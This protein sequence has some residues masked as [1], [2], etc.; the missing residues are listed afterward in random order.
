MANVIAGVEG[1]YVI[2]DDQGQIFFVDGVQGGKAVADTLNPKPTP[3]LSIACTV[4]AGRESCVIVDAKG[5][6][7][8]GPARNTGQKFS[9][10]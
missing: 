9:T 7:W 6:C 3:P 4:G 1:V 2:V 5:T 10:V 8:R